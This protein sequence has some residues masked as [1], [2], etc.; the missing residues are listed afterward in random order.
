MSSTMVGTEN[1]KL[2]GRKSY[3]NNG[4]VRAAYRAFDAHRDGRAHAPHLSRARAATPSQRSSIGDSGPELS[5]MVCPTSRFMMRRSGMR[6]SSRIASISTRVDH[7][8]V[9]KWLSGIEIA[10]EFLAHELPQQQLADGFERRVRQHQLD[11]PA[12]VFHVDAQL[13]EDGGV[14]GPCDGGEA[15]V[16]LEAIEQELH[17]RQ[18]LEG[19]AHIGE[20]H[21]DHALH[22][23]ALDGGVGTAFDAHR[24]RRRG[25]R[26]KAHRRSNR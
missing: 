2:M 16:R 13:D 23:R 14:R 15:R 22:Q 21:L 24:W 20:D 4:G 10:A 7:N 3:K 25:G 6:C 5:M 19:L 1:A 9:A 12:A 18:R 17:R 8:S 11:A 26:P